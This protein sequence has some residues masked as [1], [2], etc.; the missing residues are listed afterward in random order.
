M[1][2]GCPYGSH[3]VLEPAGALPQAAWKLDNS[4]RLY[5][6]EL[7]IDVSTLNVDSASFTQ[8]KKQ[9]QSE[10]GPDESAVAARVAELITGVVAERGKLQNPVTGSG[11]MLLGQ[12]TSVGQA[13]SG[14][15]GLQPGDRVATLVSLTLTPLVI[16]EV[17]AVRLSTDQ[18]D[19]SGRAV[20]FASGPV[21][22]LPP[23]IP[24]RLALAVLDVAGAP[25]QTARLVRPGDTVVVIGAGGKSGLLCC[26]EAR[27]RAGVTGRVIALGH[28]AASCR[29]V[30]E[31]GVSDVV[32][33]V[34]ASRPLE[35]RDRLLAATG[36]RLAD[37]TINCVNVPDTELTTILCTKDTGTIYFFSMATS[38]TK[39]ALGAEGIGS[40]ATMIVGNGYA[41]GHA[42]IA[43]HMLRQHP[44][45]RKLLERSYL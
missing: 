23:D 19:I 10:V 17:K 6:N 27:V 40:G 9:A 13:V 28:S 5:D 18:V 24:E 38:F 3:R 44:A 2:T 30:Q 42:A 22:K 45:L 25:A 15:D 11:G 31:L 16:D 34:D 39:A 33:Q 8:F 20:V 41:P 21:A 43:L 32:L 36:G 37:V 1:S 35:T 26:T 14:R 12:V 4:P 7:H 29:R